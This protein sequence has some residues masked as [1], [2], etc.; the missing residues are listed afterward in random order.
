MYYIQR[1][2]WL[3]GTVHESL[4]RT[5]DGAIIPIAEDNRD[6]RRYLEWVAEGNTAEVVE[7]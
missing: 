6:Y 5:S 4:I 1:A 2:T 3:D 7:A